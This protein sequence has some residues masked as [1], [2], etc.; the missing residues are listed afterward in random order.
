MHGWG[1]GVSSIVAKSDHCDWQSAW[2][3]L[4][5]NGARY[6]EFTTDGMLCVIGRSRRITKI[7]IAVLIRNLEVFFQVSQTGES[8]PIAGDSSACTRCKTTKLR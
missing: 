8:L 7:R 3:C 5:R 6:G 4:L 1:L 2:G